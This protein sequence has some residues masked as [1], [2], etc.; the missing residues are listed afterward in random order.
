MN[1][2]EFWNLQ[3][4]PLWNAYKSGVKSILFLFVFGN[5]F[6]SNQDAG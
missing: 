6:R 4:K 3:V 1:Y 5:S 2:E